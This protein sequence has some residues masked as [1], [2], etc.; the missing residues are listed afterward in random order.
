VALTVVVAYDISED[1]RRARTAATLQQWGDRVQ[2]SVF[3]CTLEPAALSTLLERVN[4]IIDVD[5]D[6]VYSFRQCAACWDAVG[7]LGQATV[8]DEPLFWAVL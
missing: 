5:T 8:A 6:S 1:G 2:R 7:V 4:E 3:V